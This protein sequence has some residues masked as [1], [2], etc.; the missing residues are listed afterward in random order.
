MLRKFLFL[1]VVPVFVSL[2]IAVAQDDM[3][4]LPPEPSIPVVTVQE[5]ELSVPEGKEVV[6]DVYTVKPGDYFV[7]IAS[8]EYGDKDLWKVIYRYNKYVKD[9]HW[10]FPGDK[11]ILPRVVDRLP[12]EVKPEP[13][14]ETVEETRKYGDFLAPPD[15]EF[16]AA[17]S[18]FKVNR[19]LYSQ[20]DYVFIDIGLEDGL[21][22]DMRMNIYHRS[23]PVVHPYSGEMMGNITEKI[24]EIIVTSD[25]EDYSAT[26][27]IIYC[28][29][30]VVKGDLLLFKEE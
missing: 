1:G 10:I 6:L 8:R 13:E 15:F 21:E 14:E 16:S 23:Q 18:G 12:E 28:D 27:K 2:S 9:P 22:K 30:P 26:A 24:G 11:I 25:I 19:A 29:R 17:I 3:D 5:K 7:K 4:K 20:G